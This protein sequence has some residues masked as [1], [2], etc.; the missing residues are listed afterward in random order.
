MYILII[1]YILKKKKYHMLSF[2][3]D[4]LQVV[5]VGYVNEVVSVVLHDS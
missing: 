1:I 3:V 2:C 4:D 5:C